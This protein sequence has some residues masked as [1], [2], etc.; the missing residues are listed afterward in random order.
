MFTKNGQGPFPVPSTG[1]FSGMKASTA[2]SP[3]EALTK[4]NQQLPTIAPGFK[5]VNGIM[6]VKMDKGVYLIPTQNGGRRRRTRRGTRTRRNKTH[7][8]KS[9]RHRR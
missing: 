5:V 9:R 1:M 8:R 3:Q 2:N 7:R 6:D 4:L